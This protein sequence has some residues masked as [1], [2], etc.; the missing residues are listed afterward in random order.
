MKN[1]VSTKKLIFDEKSVFNAQSGPICLLQVQRW[2]SG[3]GPKGRFRSQLLNKILQVRMGDMC[4]ASGHM[5]M[6]YVV[7]VYIVMD[8]TYRETSIWPAGGGAVHAVLL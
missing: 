6:A 8:Y 7:I 5:I 4:L 3:H 2:Q 1:R